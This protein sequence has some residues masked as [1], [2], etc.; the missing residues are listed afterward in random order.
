MPTGRGSRGIS[1][2]F[3]MVAGVAVFVVGLMGW[4]AS[5]G[6]AFPGRN[7][8]LVV[9]PFRGTGLVLVND[10][11]QHARR[12]CADRLVC[13]VPARPR[14]APDGRSI[15][16]G[17]STVRIIGLDGSCVNCRFNEFG[18]AAFL[19]DGTEVGVTSD[20]SVFRDGIDGLRQAA[21]LTDVGAAPVSSA[22]WSST[23][24]IAVVHGGRVSVGKSAALMR[25]I[26]A[27]HYPSW[28]PDGSRIAIA[29]DG[30]I[31]IVRASS[32]K[33]WRLARGDAPA[34]SP[35][36]RSVAFVS[37]RH[38]LEVIS[39][40]GGRPRRVG[41]TRAVA[42]DWQPV[43]PHPKVCNPPPGSKVLVRSRG[44]VITSNSAPPPAVDTF[45]SQA[46]MGCLRSDG[47]ERLLEK[48]DNNNFVNSEGLGATPVL[49]G[50][51]VALE[52]GAVSLRYGGSHDHLAVFDLRTGAE[53][54]GSTTVGVSCDA[55]LTTPNPCGISSFVLAKDGA[56]AAE[57]QAYSACG[58]TS[59]WNEAI[60]VHDSGGTRTLDSSTGISAATTPPLTGLRLNGNT[61]TWEHAGAPRTAQLR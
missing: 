38:W 22:V 53:R 34:F 49:N 43:M 13:G 11:G 27:G 33:G 1:V 58:A 31:W 9:Q 30:W 7:G 61:L 2:A 14:F 4:V 28:S 25:S 52:V 50:A 8:L 36:G 42:V 48:F 41:N 35:N 3:R 44:A 18:E 10:N 39:S 19:P 17:G 51:F 57:T 6:A 55:S 29:R 5:A 16:F 40:A 54:T 20:G 23:G 37:P 59:C 21:I 60:V 32:G 15:V 26:G 47:R 24:Q 56:Y 12:V 46:V 45:D